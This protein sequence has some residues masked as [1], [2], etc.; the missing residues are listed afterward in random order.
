MNAS[1]HLALSRELESRLRHDAEPAEPSGVGPEAGGEGRCGGCSQWLV[2]SSASG[3]TGNCTSA[4]SFTRS[5][6]FD[7]SSSTATVA[8]LY[9]L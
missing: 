7:P 9:H 2:G 6:E 1:Q 5:L 3:M 8:H 4:R